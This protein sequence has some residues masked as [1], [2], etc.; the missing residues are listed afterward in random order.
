MDVQERLDCHVCGKLNETILVSQRLLARQI[1]ADRF[2]DLVSSLACAKVAKCF[3]C[4]ICISPN[5]HLQAGD[6][7]LERRTIVC[8]NI[9]MAN[10]KQIEELE[11]P[12]D[13]LEL[14]IWHLDAIE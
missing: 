7:T 3:G 8:V 13:I 6:E 1:N 9:A 10:A 4:E 2:N 14:P 12:D 11:V 5:D